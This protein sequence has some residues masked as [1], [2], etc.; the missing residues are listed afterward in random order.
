[1]K[2]CSRK[3]KL[4]VVALTHWPVY[5]GFISQKWMLTAAGKHMLMK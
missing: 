5:E 3:G 4:D 2:M 1:M